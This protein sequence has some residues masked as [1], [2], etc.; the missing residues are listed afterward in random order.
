MNQS[1]HGNFI[2]IA[3]IDFPNL[4]QNAANFSNSKGPGPIPKKACESPD[5]PLKVILTDGTDVLYV[6]S[7]P[8]G[9][10]IFNAI[11]LATPLVLEA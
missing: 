5:S 8:I 6:R 2:H 9:S 3:N 1:S 4:S 10:G 7:F 11:E